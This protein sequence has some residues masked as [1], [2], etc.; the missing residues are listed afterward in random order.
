MSEN[1]NIEI[2]QKWLNKLSEEYKELS[3][4][5]DAR[6]NQLSTELDK[7][8][9]TISSIALPFY[10]NHAKNYFLQKDFGFYNHL[11]ILLAI[12]TWL[13]CLCFTLTIW[14][15]IESIRL[16]KNAFNESSIKKTMLRKL[17][18]EFSI[19]IDQDNLEEPLTYEDY[20][21]FNKQYYEKKTN[22]TNH[23]DFIT[24]KIKNHE[25]ISYYSFITGIILICFLK[26]F[27]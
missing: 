21:D 26:L 24:K 9:L 22:E 7:H 18:D 16:S 14:Q 12:F 5:H 20:E 3:D 4:K 8:L 15:T 10:L 6:Y 1:S 19:K 11:D 17:I 2:Y 25:W 27:T 23:I 13:P